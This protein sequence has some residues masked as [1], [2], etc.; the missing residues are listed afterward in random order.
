MGIMKGRKNFL[1]LVE[2]NQ[3]STLEQ[4][5]AELI[6]YSHGLQE[7]LGPPFPDANAVFSK[8]LEIKNQLEDHPCD[9]SDRWVTSHVD[10]GEKLGFISKSPVCQV[11]MSLFICGSLL[12]YMQFYSI[13]LV[14]T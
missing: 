7:L 5:Q 8:L 9:I 2:I 12:T 14:F 13:F 1:P 11:S 3:D 6:R 10:L 4:L